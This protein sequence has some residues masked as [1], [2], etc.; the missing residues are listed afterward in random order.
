MNSGLEAGM[1]G[2]AIRCSVIQNIDVDMQAS[3]LGYEGWGQR[4]D[5]LSSGRFQ[6]SIHEIKLP[7]FTLMRETSNRVLLQKGCTPRGIFAIGTVMGLAEHGYHC[8][9]IMRPR[10][11]ALLD[12]STEF[13]IRTPERFDLVAA[14]FSP[15]DLCANLGDP[16]VDYRELE[17]ELLRSSKT[18]E[19]GY[20]EALADF[21]LRAFET[22][23]ESPERLFIASNQKQLAEEF[24]ALLT[25]TIGTGQANQARGLCPNRE[26]I[27]RRVRSFLDANPESALSITDIC[28]EVGVTRRTLQNAIQ[29]VFG[30]SPQHYL[31]AIRLNGFRRALKAC[32]PAVS[33][34]DVAA[35]WGFWHLSQLA[36]DYRR[37]FGELPSE[38]RLRCLNA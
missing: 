38:T 26:R 35:R 4:Y 11:A 34:G 10:S 17:N 16:G 19:S 31:K 22:S 15:E 7:A 23:Q 28:D 12:P 29:E 36:Q 27:V 1:G 13:E 6:G 20:T 24:Y 37:L 25:E 18:I 2:N 32:S 33:I 3:A 21:L 9:E 5:Q 14:V 30:I 8:G